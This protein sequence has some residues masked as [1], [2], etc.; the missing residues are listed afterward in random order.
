MGDIEDWISLLK[1][2]P[3]SVSSLEGRVTMGKKNYI[4][5]GMS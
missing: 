2:S 5:K 3:N 1:K 4:S